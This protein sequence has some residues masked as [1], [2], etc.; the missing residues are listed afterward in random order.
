MR[1]F[2]RIKNGKCFSRGIDCKSIGDYCEYCYEGTCYKCNFKDY[3][4]SI[5]TCDDSFDDNEGA[6]IIIGCKF[7]ALFFICIIGIPIYIFCKR[8]DNNINNINNNRNNNMNNNR[9]NNI[10][11]YFVN[12]S[13]NNNNNRVLPPQQITVQNNNINN[14]AVEHNTV[15][16]E[17]KFLNVDREF[18]IQKEALEKEYDFYDYC[19]F[20]PAKYKS[21][22]GCILC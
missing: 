14:I 8:K 13:N 9:N 20:N 19:K 21:D 18:E 17:E 10:T 3:F 6:G 11:R 12:K 1:I 4:G 2:S 15:R 7:G 22:C 5:D 16:S